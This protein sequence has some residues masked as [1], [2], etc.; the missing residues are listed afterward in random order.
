MHKNR[1]PIEVTNSCTLGLWRGKMTKG[2]AAE[3]Q[4]VRETQGIR[5]H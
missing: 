5:R 1:L 4:E 3:I 2:D